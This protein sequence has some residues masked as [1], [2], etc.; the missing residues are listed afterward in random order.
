MQDTRTHWKVGGLEV[1][2][3]IFGKETNLDVTTAIGS[4]MVSS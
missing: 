4:F 1:S 3:K 2:T